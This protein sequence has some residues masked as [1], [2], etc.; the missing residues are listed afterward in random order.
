MIK[1]NLVCLVIET[2][3]FIQNPL[4]TMVMRMRRE[5]WPQNCNIT[6]IAKLTSFAME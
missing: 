3:R 6:M 5:R 1:L 4:Y 2:T